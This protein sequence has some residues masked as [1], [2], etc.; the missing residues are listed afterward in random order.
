MAV[1]LWIGLVSVTLGQGAK[2][3]VIRYDANGRP[4]VQQA[5]E[6]K[7]VLTPQGSKLVST[8]AAV[9]QNGQ[10]V[11]EQ[12]STAATEQISSDTRRSE[13]TIKIRDGNG[14]FKTISKAVMTEKQI[15]SDTLQ[16]DTVFQEAR[17]S[18]GDLMTTARMREVRK[19]LSDGEEYQRTIETKTAN[20]DFR[21]SQKVE[22]KKRKYSNGSSRTRTIESAYDLN[23]NVRPER[24]IIERE[25]T[26]IWGKKN[27]ERIIREIET[28][29]GKKL[30]RVEEE[31]RDPRATSG[32]V[33]EK[34]V[35]Q[36]DGFF[37]LRETQ[38]VT[39]S[40]EHQWG[41]GPYKMTV[42]K[43]RPRN[44]RFG[45]PVV[46][47]IEIERKVRGSD[48]V[49]VVEKELRVRDANGTFKTVSVTQ[50][51]STNGQR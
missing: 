37:G 3:L 44:N 39:T 19:E 34:V 1:S 24:E 13:S 47:Q 51:E 41:S 48:G 2:I 43:E 7:S 38:R 18:R 21:P 49:E 14:N 30:L 29:G 50:V 16:I 33:N 22:S 17:N 36:P 23:G 27:I 12:Q 9:G 11:V 15:T 20:G 10:A 32:V 40:I 46:T 35:K 28:D 5:A 8:V 31:L 42:T 25:T 26:T 6:T 45:G 4:Q